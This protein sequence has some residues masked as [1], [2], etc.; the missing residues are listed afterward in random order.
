MK[1]LLPPDDAYAALPRQIK[2]VIR[3]RQIKAALAVNQELIE[4]YWK[5]GKMIV[6]EQEARG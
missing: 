2:S 5:I 6:R 4:L 1:S 3:S